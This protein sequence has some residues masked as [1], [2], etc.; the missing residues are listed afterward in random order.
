ME[1]LIF[2]AVSI[3]YIIV[4]LGFTVW[5]HKRKFVRNLN[6]FLIAGWA[7]GGSLIGM[8]ML[9]GWTNAFTIF[10][11]SELSAVFTFPN[12]MILLVVGIMVPMLMGIFIA[13]PL[14]RKFAKGYGIIDFLDKRFNSVSLRSWGYICCIVPAFLMIFANLFM[15]GAYGTALT[16]IPLE[17]L[18]LMFAI[19]VIIYCTIGGWWHVLF[20]DF[21]QF[22][23]TFVGIAIFLIVVLSQFGGIEGIY[24]GIMQ[25]NP[26]FFGFVSSIPFWKL[27]VVLF[28]T[29]LA[30]VFAAQYIWMGF[31]SGKSEKEMNFAFSSFFFG[32]LPVAALGFVSSLVAIS[33]NID[34]VAATGYIGDAPIVILQ[35][36]PF[37]LTVLV[38]LII[39]QFAITTLDTQLVASSSLTEIGVIRPIAKLRGVKLSPGREMSISRIII[40]V[41]GLLATFFALNKIGFLEYLFMLGFWQVS[42][43]GMN[44]LGAY[45]DKVT[46]WPAIIG[47]TVGTLVGAYYFFILNDDFVGFTLM[48]IIS[49]VLMVILSYVP[50]FN[51]KKFDFKT[52]QEVKR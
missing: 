4:M 27:V 46:K 43:M 50:P 3:L 44:A 49:L 17:Y 14:K 28:L 42:I 33:Q 23:F 11:N 24:N 52:M 38:W 25:V 2:I 29:I 6:D 40:V 12:Y 31:Q 7:I 26:G 47:T 13:K 10:V 21:V 36:L 8:N 15:L 41:L 9:A 51:K 37:W 20:T 19:L 16:G 39:L 30:G 45:W 22:M 5:M 34:V 35:Y 48:L 18:V 32:Y 1:E